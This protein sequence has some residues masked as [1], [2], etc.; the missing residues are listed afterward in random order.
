MRKEKILSGTMTLLVL[1][2]LLS[3][4]SYGYQLE[5]YLAGK[6]GRPV[7]PGTIYVILN[8][9]NRRKFIT[10]KEKKLSHGRRITVYRITAA[11]REF[12]KRHQEPLAS[13]RKVIDELTDT[14]AAMGR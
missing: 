3:E 5:T 12:L 1:C 2:R 8:S 11:G 13:V 9:L 10:V 7:P 4:P 6:L 14:I